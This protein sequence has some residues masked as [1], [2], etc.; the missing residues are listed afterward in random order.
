MGNVRRRRH[1]GFAEPCSVPDR[2]WRVLDL[3]SLEDHHGCER[4]MHGRWQVHLMIPKKPFKKGIGPSIVPY[5]KVAS[6]GGTTTLNPSDK[7][8]NITLS[9]G[10]L[11]ATNSGAGN[12][13][14]RSISSY[15]S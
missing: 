1:H 6:G 5:Y 2:C 14:V 7:N 15:S 9:G 8:A 10:N 12:G 13:S 4:H 3:W 11:I